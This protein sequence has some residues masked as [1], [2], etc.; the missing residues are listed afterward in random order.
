MGCL[1]LIS[2][3]ISCFSLHCKMFSVS[4]LQMYGY[5]THTHTQT[6]KVHMARGINRNAI[7]RAG[8]EKLTNTAYRIKTKL[9]KFQCCICDH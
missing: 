9:L 3:H 8:K 2:D 7:I 1:V 4:S 6:Q 5:T